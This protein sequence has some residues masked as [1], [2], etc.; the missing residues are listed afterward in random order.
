MFGDGGSGGIDD[1]PQWVVALVPVE[2]PVVAGFPGQLLEHAQTRQEGEFFADV[3][4]GY[5]DPVGTLALEERLLL[6]SHPDCQRQPQAPDP[7][8]TPAVRPMPGA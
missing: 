1:T 7:R 6:V 8:R 5:S 4:G 2:D 3:L